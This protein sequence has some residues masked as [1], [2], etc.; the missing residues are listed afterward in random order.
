MHNIEPYYNWRPLY[1]S[2]EDPSSPFY[3]KEYSEFHCVDKIYDHYIHPQWD[4][5]G[6][7]TLYIKIIFTDYE[8]EFTIIELIGEWNDLLHN[9]IMHFKR[10]ILESLMNHGVSKFILV[11]ENVL[12]F[13]YS[14]DCYYEEWFEEVLDVDG[15]IAIMN[16]RQHVF[17]DFQ[18]A[19]ID[20]YLVSGGT[21]NELSWRT[22]TPDTLFEKVEEEV[23]KRIGV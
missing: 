3:Q 1:I 14:D 20:S 7:P 21:L 8:R 17:E 19:N 12:N 9:D 15:W 11:A 23:L 13:H 2:S 22:K 16:L 4:N 5:M 18:T 6:S 10:N